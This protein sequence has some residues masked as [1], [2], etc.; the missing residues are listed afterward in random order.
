MELNKDEY[1]IKALEISADKL[2]KLPVWF[3]HILY[4]KMIPKE[5]QN[6]DVKF[7]A[8]T[9]GYH[10]YHPSHRPISTLINFDPIKKSETN[11]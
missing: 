4:N 6:L 5:E 10:F 7:Q 3:G 2:N 9:G 8:E 11:E 1:E